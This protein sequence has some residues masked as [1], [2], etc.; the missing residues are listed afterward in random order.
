MI[1]K[2][3]KRIGSDAKR[4]LELETDKKLNLIEVTFENEDMKN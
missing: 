3:L 4:G 1:A 2:D